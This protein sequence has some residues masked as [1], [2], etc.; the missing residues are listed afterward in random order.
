MSRTNVFPVLIV[1]TDLH[2]G[3]PMGSCCILPSLA[4]RRG[5]RCSLLDTFD[6]VNVYGAHLIATQP[7]RNSSL[8][9]LEQRPA[10]RL[11]T[12]YSSCNSNKQSR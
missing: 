9:S 4:A 1:S 3:Q 7:A 2:V 8:F 5:P 10:D 11:G 6:D 12:L